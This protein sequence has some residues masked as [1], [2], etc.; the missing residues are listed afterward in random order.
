MAKRSPLSS[1]S[2]KKRLKAAF[3]S[4]SERFSTSL[5]LLSLIPLLSGL[6]MFSL[7]EI[8]EINLLR[9]DNDGY[10]YPFNKEL[11]GIVWG[12][13]GISLFLLLRY[14][15]VEWRF[16]LTSSVSAIILV[17][18]TVSLFI[19]PEK[20]YQG[21]STIIFYQFI[22]VVILPFNLAFLLFTSFNNS[23]SG[24]TPDASPWGY[25]VNGVFSLEDALFF[26]QVFDVIWT[27][28]VF[29]LLL[30]CFVIEARLVQKEQTTSTTSDVIRP[31]FSFLTAALYL[32]PYFAIRITL[33][34]NQISS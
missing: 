30:L 13:V 19:L 24:K 16:L 17:I 8:F 31:L 11:F 29:F 2:L 3:Q 6:F 5:F 28:I 33:T 4:E 32:C 23:L 25:N 10:V 9:M 34:L 22:Y 15:K 27:S 20:E 26:R 18:F 14:L 12:L 1:R 7:V 21:F